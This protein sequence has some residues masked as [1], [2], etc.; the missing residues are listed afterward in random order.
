M[1][2]WVCHTCLRL[3]QWFMHLCIM[4]II[5]VVFFRKNKRS[6]KIS[7][8]AKTA[9]VYFIYT[10]F[11]EGVSKITYIMSPVELCGSIVLFCRTMSNR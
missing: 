1:D 7:T 5:I 3:V 6:E 4:C 11:I 2:S 10:L 9:Q 8:S